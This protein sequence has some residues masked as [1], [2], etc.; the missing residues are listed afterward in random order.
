MYE[1]FTAQ[2]RKIIA[3]AGQVAR[4]RGAAAIG[5]EHVLEA[6]FTV[7]DTA[8]ITVLTGF[9]VDEAA[10]TREV[11]RLG[12]GDPGSPGGVIGFGATG[13]VALHMAARESADLGHDH[14]GAAHLLLGL[15]HPEAGAAHAVLTGLGV[16]LDAARH[17]V[18]ELVRASQ[19]T[20]SS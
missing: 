4:R 10:V 17:V 6:L 20:T 18:A 19:G 9:G 2:A 15:L 5:G 7:P 11:D 8:A 12:P 1:R 13:A 3:G 14:V 16:R